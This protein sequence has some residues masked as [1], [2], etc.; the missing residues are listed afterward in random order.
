MPPLPLF[1]NFLKFEEIFLN[2]LTFIDFGTKLVKNLK[3]EK[4]AAANL[5]KN[6]KLFK[7]NRFK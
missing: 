4:S 1:Q 3:Y 6:N 2:T 7:T 5:A